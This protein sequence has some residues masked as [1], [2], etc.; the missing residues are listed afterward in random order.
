MAMRIKTEKLVWRGEKSRKITGIGG[1][2]ASE[3]LPIEYLK[4]YPRVEWTPDKWGGLAIYTDSGDRMR[5]LLH[6]I[7]TEAEFQVRLEWIEKAGERL[8]RIRQKEKELKEN[9][10]GEETFI[11]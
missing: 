5:L 6:E 9:W 7:Y 10:K 3:E 4:G 8:Y 2:I 11:I 1:V